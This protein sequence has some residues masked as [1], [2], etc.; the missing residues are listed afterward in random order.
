[1][2]FYITFIHNESIIVVLFNRGRV[3][4]YITF[5][6]AILVFTDQYDFYLL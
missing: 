3:C 4:V 5:I 2:S 1:M 6:V